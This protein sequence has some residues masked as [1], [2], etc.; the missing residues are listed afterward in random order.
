MAPIVRFYQPK[1]GGTRLELLKEGEEYEQSEITSEIALYQEIQ[2]S[3]DELRGELA[4]AEGLELADYDDKITKM[5]DKLLDI[6]DYFSYPNRTE[7]VTVRDGDWFRPDQL[8]SV[9][10]ENVGE[11]GSLAIDGVNSTW[12]QSDITGTRVLTVRIRSHKKRVER[13]RFRTTSGDKRT[14]LQNMSIKIAGAIPRLDKPENLADSG[15]NLPDGVDPWIEHTLAT[16]KR[17]RYLRIEADGA[18][19]PNGDHVRIREVEVFV[20]THAYK[21]DETA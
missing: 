4:I 16:P 17:G 13:I 5:L 21:G 3:S 10:D 18:L 14:R 11:E 12:W 1:S 15:V 7:N 6:N 9:S 19:A 2:A 20:T 8:E